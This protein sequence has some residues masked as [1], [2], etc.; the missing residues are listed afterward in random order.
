MSVN[1]TVYK[2]CKNIVGRLYS[3]PVVK[4]YSDEKYHRASIGEFLENYDFNQ[5]PTITKVGNVIMNLLVIMINVN[6]RVK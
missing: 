3:Y 6:F 2:K 1:G 5:V 4:L